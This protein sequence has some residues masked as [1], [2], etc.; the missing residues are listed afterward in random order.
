MFGA[1]RQLAHVEVGGKGADPLVG[2]NQVVLAAVDGGHDVLIHLENLRLQLPDLI[3]QVVARLGG[4]AVVL[5]RQEHALKMHG[6]VDGVDL[7]LQLFRHKVH[8]PDVLGVLLAL[9]KDSVDGVVN[10]RGEFL[11]ILPRYA[12]KAELDILEPQNPPDVVIQPGKR[13]HLVHGF[14]KGGP[15]GQQF[16]FL[17]REFG[18]LAV[19]APDGLK[20]R[21]QGNPPLAA[22]GQQL[23]VALPHSLG[24]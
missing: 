7:V 20:G 1:G 23:V 16:I 12:A 17:L 9:K 5:V 15:L 8:D 4:C 6:R 13:N 21:L 22:A 24:L 14:L 11:V 2:G 18:E 3:L 10:V 19:Q